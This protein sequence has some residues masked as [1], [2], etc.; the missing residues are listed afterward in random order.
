MPRDYNFP[1]SEASRMDELKHPD[2]ETA[3]TKMLEA[4]EDYLK[5]FKENPDARTK[6]V[7]FGE[8]NK[9]E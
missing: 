9:F 6:N 5:Y 3:K 1:L 8:L 7:V 2:L 4:R